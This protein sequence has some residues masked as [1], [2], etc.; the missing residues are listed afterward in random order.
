MKKQLFGLAA[1][2]MM[3]FSSAP[4]AAAAG[5]ETFD[6]QLKGLTPDGTY[7]Y[8]IWN[9]EHRGEVFFDGD[10]TDGGSFSCKWTD[11]HDCMFTKGHCF[12]LPK[13]V[14]YKRLGSISCEY[15][16]DYSSN[17][18]SQ[19]GVHGWIHN[20]TPPGCT[21][22]LVEFFIIDGYNNVALPRQA[23]QLGQITDN[24]YTYDIYCACL[25]EYE[26]I[27]PKLMYYHYYSVI[28][29]EDNP[30]KEGEPASVSHR[31]DVDKH[32][33]AW[34]QA[35]IY[36]GGQLC[37]ISLFVSGFDCSG[38]ATVSKN[39]LL[40]ANQPSSI[41]RGD[42]NGD[43]EFN[44]A[45]YVLLRKWLLADPDTALFSMDAAD[46]NADD[47][48][49]AIDLSLIMRAL[50]GDENTQLPIDVFE[51]TPA[52]TEIPQAL[53]EHYSKTK[54]YKPDFYSVLPQLITDEYGFKVYKDAVGGESWLEYQEELY[55]LSA[56]FTSY[57]TVSFATADL[58]QDGAA[59][60]YYTCSGG[61]DAHASKI[62]YFDSAEYCV[63]ELS[64]TYWGTV[65]DSGN[66]DIG[67]AGMIFAA[68]NDTLAV[69]AA[70]LIIPDDPEAPNDLTK[71]KLSGTPDFKLGEL[72]AEDG[73]IQLFEEEI[74]EPLI[75]GEA[76]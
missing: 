36:L 19:F 72:F 42:V 13:D 54:A 1:A 60:L 23:T 4:L 32:F 64:Y 16:M 39:E 11:V 73:K 29:E 62:G 22:R 61:S 75:H 44:M 70:H 14:S 38:E 12:D 31:I 65:E 48:L 5:D 50:T 45:D 49:D 46:V 59:E 30:V 10:K 7:N 43:E 27:A 34:E 56:N 21:P 51:L 6:L 24:G 68:E 35:D 52:E 41:V 69:F 71:V 33:R 3:A 28:T 66:S 18:Y 26:W 17:G 8:E 57:G 15:E 40:F 47:R 53:A 37:D 63:R 25:T 76:A 9:A 2:L 74:T 58:N 67:P 55:P 20:S